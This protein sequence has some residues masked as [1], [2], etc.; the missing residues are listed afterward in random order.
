MRQHRHSRT[1]WGSSNCLQFGSL[2][3]EAVQFRGAGSSK[4]KGWCAFRMGESGCCRIRGGRTAEAR[5]LVAL[6]G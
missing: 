2:Q 1:L 4:G 3:V 5:T 6:D